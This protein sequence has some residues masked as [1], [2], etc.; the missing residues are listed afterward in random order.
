M[1]QNEIEQMRA[2][3][4][5]VPVSKDDEGYSFKKI[6]NSVYGF[7]YAPGNQ[8]FG[9]FL[10]QPRQSYEVHKL[11]DGTILILGY[12]TTEFAEKLK[13][14]GAQDFQMYPEPREEYNVLVALPHDRIANAKALDRD[15]FNKFKASLRPSS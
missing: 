15:D 5:V 10:K 9:L 1:S 11:A 4:R 3:H 7:T 14:T 2:T 12:T 6:A 8:D 13:S